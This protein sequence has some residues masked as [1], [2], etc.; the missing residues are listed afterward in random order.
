MLCCLGANFTEC[1]RTNSLAF[2]NFIFQGRSSLLYAS[3]RNR[4]AIARILL[5]EMADINLQD[6]LGATPLH[7]AVGC[8]HVE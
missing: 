1:H 7:R 8:G 5:D 2:S 6:K 4:Q 3:S